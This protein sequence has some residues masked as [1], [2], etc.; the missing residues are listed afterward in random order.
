MRR[1]PLG[2]FEADWLEID[3][4]GRVN[5]LIRHENNSFLVQQRLFFPWP[6]TRRLPGV[7]AEASISAYHSVAGSPGGKGVTA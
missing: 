6:I 7:P 2:E 1:Y 3:D 4:T 5:T